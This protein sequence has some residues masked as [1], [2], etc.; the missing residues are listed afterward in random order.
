MQFL[1]IIPLIRFVLSH[2]AFFALMVTNNAVIQQVTQI[3]TNLTQANPQFVKYLHNSSF[4]F[5]KLNS[6]QFDDQNKPRLDNLINY[7]PKNLCNISYSVPVLFAGTTIQKNRTLIGKM[8]AMSSQVI[9]TV[10]SEINRQLN[11]SQ[12][13]ATDVFDIYSP[14]MDLLEL[15]DSK[16]DD[17]LQIM[18]NRT[19]DF[20]L[21]A[22]DFVKEIVLL[23][24]S[25][26][27]G[28]FHDVLARAPLAPC[29]N[30]SDF[31]IHLLTNN[32]VPIGLAY[33]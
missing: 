27:S 3:Q 16:H 5:V 18:T 4:L 14:K 24:A 7:L 19:A 21:S 13:N 17:L 2:D 1:L 23:N 32:R 28:S 29:A 25:T 9:T 8:N 6:I 26:S 30:I 11:Q 33:I 10:H 20:H 15:D 12:I 22:G 31:K